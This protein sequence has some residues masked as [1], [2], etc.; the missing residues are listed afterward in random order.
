MRTTDSYPVGGSFTDHG[1]TPSITS[2]DI[3]H[4]GSC[5]LIK[6]LM[7]LSKGQCFIWVVYVN[8]LMKSKDKHLHYIYSHCTYCA[9]DGQLH[10]REQESFRLFF[11][12][13][14]CSSWYRPRSS[15][16][17]SSCGAYARFHWPVSPSASYL[18]LIVREGR[19]LLITILMVSYPYTDPQKPYL[20]ALPSFE[21]MQDF[22]KL[23]QRDTAFRRVF[24]STSD[25]AVGHKSEQKGQRRPP[26]QKLGTTS[27]CVLTQLIV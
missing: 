2:E 26:H 1:D 27:S 6:L 24:S 3:V 7:C 12:R 13:H 11:C 8:M 20:T 19:A 15:Y 14:A 22:L 16:R 23:V 4:T 9:A 5:F 17:I 10:T 21:Y 18:V 25:G